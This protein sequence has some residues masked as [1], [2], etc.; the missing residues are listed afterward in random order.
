M[1]KENFLAYFKRKSQS[2]D[3]TDGI[4]I[5]NVST[6]LTKKLL[7][8]I[9]L[10]L[11]RRCKRHTSARENIKSKSLRGLRKKLACMQENLVLLQQLKGSLLSIRNILLSEPQLTPGR[12][13][14][15][16]VTGPLSRELED[17]T[18]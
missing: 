1:N 18:C 3:K 4:Q 16:M 2:K 6:S 11:K 17:P 15:M 13:S 10:P 7:Q 12:R 14:A 5:T 9:L 8:R